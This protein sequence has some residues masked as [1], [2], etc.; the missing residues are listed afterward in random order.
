VRIVAF[1]EFLNLPP[2]TVY[3]DYRPVGNFGALCI[4][5]DTCF[6]KTGPVDFYYA[7]LCD[8][9]AL[10]SDHAA[11]LLE[12]AQEPGGSVPVAFDVFQ[13]EGLFDPGALYAVWEAKDVAGLIAALQETLGEKTK[14]MGKSHAI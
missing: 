10:S 5:Q 8:V 11:E 14:E 2:G 4:K 3:C 9:D 12:Q 13:R 1:E 7:S 6:G